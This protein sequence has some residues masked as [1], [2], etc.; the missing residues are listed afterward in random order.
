MTLPA[1]SVM[2]PLSGVAPHD[3]GPAHSSNWLPVCGRGQGVGL[4]GW[5]CVWPPHQWYVSMVTSLSDAGRGD[6]VYV[7][8]ESMYQTGKLNA[9]MVNV[10]TPIRALLNQLMILPGCP[11]GLLGILLLFRARY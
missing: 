11:G 3:E 9:G 5:G 2:R 8:G 1:A 10:L 4:G 7:G 6:D